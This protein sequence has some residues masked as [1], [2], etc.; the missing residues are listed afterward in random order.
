VLHYLWLVKADWRE[1]VVYG[2]ILIGLLAMRSDFVPKK[3]RYMRII[4]H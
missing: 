4:R 3:I 1:P 2:L